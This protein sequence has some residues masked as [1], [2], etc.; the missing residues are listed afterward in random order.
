MDGLAARMPAAPSG[1]PRASVVLTAYND[2]RFL[3]E[4]VD[5]I[6]RQEFRDFEFI[7]VDD[8][9]GE[10]ARFDALARR[11]PRIKILVN[12]TNLGAA[13]AANRGI[14]NARGD[15][16]VRLDADDVAEPSRLRRL[17]AALDEDAQLGLVGSAV[18]VIDEDGR[19]LATERMP[20][21]DVEI[22][23]T[24]LFRNPFYHSAVAF[25]RSCFEQAGRYR[26][27]ERVSYDHY[28]W[29]DMLPFCR[30]R[31]LSEPLTRYR[32]NSRGLT[33]T[34]SDKPRNR[35]HHIRETLWARLGLTY[36]LYDDDLALDVTNFLRG[37]EI[38]APERRAA[39]Y[40]KMTTVLRA[41]IAAPD[42]TARRED[43][44]AAR[45]FARALVARM[46]ASPPAGLREMLA[47]CCACWPIDRSAATAVALA[48]LREELR[49]LTKIRPVPQAN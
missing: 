8:A 48:R 31:N 10:Q 3:D 39:A 5:S 14:T 44:E 36:D 23:W 43:A 28:L 45:R 18:T 15:I 34:H 11:D 7:I 47:T 32:I 25:R 35:T 20:Q 19:A 22:R 4:A 17:I 41:F 30:A 21:T 49:K 24:I 46:M 1:H 2:L 37:L 27:A 38:A 26:V 29:F 13:A 42:R 40:R 33:A 9:T 12:E 16:I 6:L